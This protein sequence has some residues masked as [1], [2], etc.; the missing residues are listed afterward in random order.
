MM[1]ESDRDPIPG[2]LSRV[3]RPIINRLIE[4]SIDVALTPPLP[5]GAS[6]DHLADRAIDLAGEEF[7]EGPSR[8]AQ[9]AS[10]RCRGSV[11]V[12]AHQGLRP[13][14]AAGGRR[15]ETDPLAGPAPGRPPR[16]PTSTA[17]PNSRRPGACRPGCE[18]LGYFSVLVRMR[19]GACCAAIRHG[20]R[21][22]RLRRRKRPELGGAV[23]WPAE[24][25]V[26][27][28][29]AGALTAPRTHPGPP[30]AA[31]VHTGRS[32]R[33]GTRSAGWPAGP[34][35]AP[36]VGLGGAAIRNLSHQLLSVLPQAR[37]ADVD[38]AGSQGG[39]EEPRRVRVGRHWLLRQKPPVPR[40][41]SPGLP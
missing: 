33:P 12:L 7:G 13:L 34:A 21:A 37:H 40:R 10:P 9:R 6:R 39:D 41:R 17:A 25:G 29:P 14:R 2:L 4:P 24:P 30:L 23:T 28:G 27:Y 1:I 20:T 38:C 8:P 15:L 35:G 22:K 36:R 32:Q 16:P 19:G 18:P 5:S 31:T 26:P 3:S 11:E